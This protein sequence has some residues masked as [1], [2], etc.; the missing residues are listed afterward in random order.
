MRAY[1]RDPA[2]A[3]EDGRRGR[4]FVA[5]TFDRRR[6]AERYAR[7]LEEIAPLSTSHR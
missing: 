1:L 2:R 3:D 7:M 5:R 6:I 4:E